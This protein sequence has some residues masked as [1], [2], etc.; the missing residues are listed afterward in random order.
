MSLPINVGLI[1]FSF[2]SDDLFKKT[3]NVSSSI[4]DTTNRRDIT[5]YTVNRSRLSDEGLCDYRKHESTMEQ[6]SIR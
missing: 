5:K 6:S 4:V 2:H 1:Q 3:I